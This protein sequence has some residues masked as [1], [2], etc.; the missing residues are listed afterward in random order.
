M[1]SDSCFYN[2]AM[3]AMVPEKLEKLDII[4]KKIVVEWL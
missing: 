1:T 4:G 2:G 3:Y